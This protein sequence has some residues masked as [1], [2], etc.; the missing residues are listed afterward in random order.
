MFTDSQHTAEGHFKGHFLHGEGKITSSYGIVTTGLFF[1]NKPNGLMTLELN[2][3]LI[4][5][6]KFKMGMKE[7][8]G[9]KYG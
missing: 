4:F 1:E 2:G 8:K 5:K 6:G 9:I 7:G 3:R